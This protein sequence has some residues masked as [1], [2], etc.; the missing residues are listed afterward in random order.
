MQ[1]IFKERKRNSII[2]IRHLIMKCFALFSLF[3]L[4]TTKSLSLPLD[5]LVFYFSKSKEICRWCQYA[6][7]ISGPSTAWSPS[8]SPSSSLINAVTTTLKTI[9]YVSGFSIK[10]K[11]KRICV[12]IYFYFFPLMWHVLLKHLIILISAGMCSLFTHLFHT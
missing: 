7:F 3:L 4:L 6:T 1:S 5:Q 12:W 2:T 9:G 11:K 10:K 8:P